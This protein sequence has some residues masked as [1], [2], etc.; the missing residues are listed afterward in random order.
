MYCSRTYYIST[1]EETCLNDFSHQNTSSNKTNTNVMD[2]LTA[3]KHTHDRYTFTHSL[4]HSYTHARPHAHT[5]TKTKSS[6]AP[7]SQ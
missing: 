7:V 5:R 2:T 1:F 4:T 3:H 6:D